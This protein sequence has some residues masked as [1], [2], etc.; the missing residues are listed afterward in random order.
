L[1][2]KEEISKVEE[3]VPLSNDDLSMQR[4]L[5]EE[6]EKFILYVYYFF[7]DFCFSPSIFF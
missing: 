3:E 2:T 4:G 6:V 1:K 5:E 7:P